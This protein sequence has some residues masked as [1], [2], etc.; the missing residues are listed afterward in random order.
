MAQGNI[1][2]IDDEE[3]VGEVLTLHL[4]K[5]GFETVEAKDGAEVIQLMKKGSN[6]V[7]VGLIIC[8]I[9]MPKITGVEAIN[10]LRKNAASIPV[11]AIKGYADT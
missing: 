3:E 2:I 8:D 5:G 4:K 1:L 7:N 6:L 11:L 10:F 9:R